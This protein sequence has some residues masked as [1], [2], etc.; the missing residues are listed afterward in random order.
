MIRYFIQ[1]FLFLLLLPIFICS[2]LVAQPKEDQKTVLLAI[3]ARNKSHTLPIFL[4]CIENLNYD[5]KQISLYI[6]TN[7][8]TDITQEILETWVK[9]KGNLYKDVIFVKHDLNVTNLTTRPHE[10][11]PERFKILAKIRND[12]LEQAQKLKADYYFVVDC[13]NFITSDVLKDLIKADKPI[14]APM[15]RSLQHDNLYSN[16]FCEIDE[17]GYWGHHPDYVD[18]VSYQKTGV[19]KVPV[20]HCTYLIQ[21]KFLNQLN[22]I[23]GSDDYEFV[24]FS[25]KAR[26]NHIDQ[27]IDNEKK[28]GYLVHFSDDL[29]LEEERDRIANINV[30]QMMKELR[31]DNHK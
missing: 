2:E 18:I 8:N 15:L 7:N 14:I 13:D 12:S 9:E 6:N 23:D 3:L 16:F 24:I 4:K 1:K 25:K 5:K 11:T 10:W 22:Y 19:F 17:A 20:V 31:S 21:S 27:Y 29:S 26:E 30:N 28:Y